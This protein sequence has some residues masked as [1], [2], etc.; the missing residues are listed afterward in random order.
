MPETKKW[1]RVTETLVT[2]DNK[3]HRL[4]SYQARIYPGEKV[5]TISVSPSYDEQGVYLGEIV[6]TYQEEKKK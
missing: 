2:P 5:K 3:S 6:T 1:Y 4:H